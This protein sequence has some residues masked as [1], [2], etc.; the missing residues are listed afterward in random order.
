MAHSNG[1][2]F[3]CNIGELDGVFQWPT[4]MC[5]IYGAIFVNWVGYLSG[6]LKCVGLWVKYWNIG[7]S[8]GVFECPT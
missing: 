2:D 8:S 1:Q 5:G 6:P 3:R 7:E 4:K